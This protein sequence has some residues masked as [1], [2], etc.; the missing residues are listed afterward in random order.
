MKCVRGNGLASNIFLAAQQTQT[1]H[2]AALSN[3]P[4]GSDPLCVARKHNK[5]CP[6]KINFFSLSRIFVRR[7]NKKMLFF[8]LHFIRG[9]QSL[10]FTLVIMTL[11]GEP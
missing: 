3:S 2:A 10:I 6:D 4:S 8:G 5:G 1:K 11:S 9:K 7:I